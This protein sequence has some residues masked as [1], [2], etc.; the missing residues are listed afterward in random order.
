MYSRPVDSH[1]DDAK[2]VR[3]REEVMK[4]SNT[5]CD[6]GCYPY[7]LSTLIA[8]HE[9]KKHAIES[10]FSGNTF[11]FNCLK[12]LKEWLTSI[13]PEQR[14]LV[15]SIRLVIICRSPIDKDSREHQASGWRWR[16]FFADETGTQLP[17]LR[18]MNLVIYISGPMSCWRRSQSSELNGVFEPLRD[19]SLKKLTIVINEFGKSSPRS[20]AFSEYDEEHRV[21]GLRVASGREGR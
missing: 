14:A 19:I 13:T 4:E 18:S 21:G 3:S 1:D 17:N 11:S 20:C 12:T 2:I 9:S 6:Q 8:T 16:Q 7:N 5:E 15:R 10:L